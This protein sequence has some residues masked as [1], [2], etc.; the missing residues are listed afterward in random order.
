[1]PRKLTF[2]QAMTRLEK[3]VQD[4]ENS[5]M[6][7]DKSL[8]EFEEGVELVRFCSAKLE[9]TKKKVEMLVKKNG[10]MLKEP[11]DIEDVKGNDA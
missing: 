5:G 1:M 10:K 9:E 11:L 4:M 6:D 7:L 8:K 3:I 2:E